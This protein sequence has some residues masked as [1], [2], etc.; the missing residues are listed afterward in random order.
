MCVLMDDVLALSGTTGTPPVSSMVVVSVNGA[1]ASVPT[2]PNTPLSPDDW[3]T[4]SCPTVPWM[5]TVTM[6]ADA[7]L[8]NVII[9]LTAAKRRSSDCA[10]DSEAANA[11]MSVEIETEAETESVRL[12]KR[13]GEERENVTGHIDA[14]EELGIIVAFA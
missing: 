9:T 8:A 10:A 4:P 1:P 2:G 3:S 12:K 5:L 14:R 11:W 7:T 6:V 13:N